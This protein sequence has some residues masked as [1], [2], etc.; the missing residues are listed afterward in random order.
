MVRM[1]GRYGRS[2]WEGQPNGNN[3]DLWISRQLQ[4]IFRANVNK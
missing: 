2:K 4:T 3:I 1:T